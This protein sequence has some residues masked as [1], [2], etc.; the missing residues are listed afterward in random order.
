MD[1]DR[2]SVLLGKG[3]GSFPSR[4]DYVTGSL[5]SGVAVGLFNAD[6]RP[7]LVVSNSGSNTVSVFLNTSQ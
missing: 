6:P 5:P 1:T 4:F 3:D 7:D 2:V